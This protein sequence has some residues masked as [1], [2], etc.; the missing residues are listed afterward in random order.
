MIKFGWAQPNTGKPA[1]LKSFVCKF[2]F[3][4]IFLSNM[5]LIYLKENM[6]MIKRWL[7]SQCLVAPSQQRKGLAECWRRF[8][9]E[10][11]RSRSRL[12][13]KIIT[14]PPETDAK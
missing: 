4:L 7:V 14:M 3:N 13:G 1:T 12:S 6:T 5:Y 8:L 2:K 10:P 11:Q 9:E